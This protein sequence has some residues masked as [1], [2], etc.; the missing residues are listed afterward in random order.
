MYR[1]K[2]FPTG[3]HND[4]RFIHLGMSD[5]EFTGRV[6]ER[7]TAHLAGLP[8][9][10]EEVIAIHHHPPVRELFYP[11]ALTTVDQRVWLAYSGNRRMQDAVLSD[12]RIITVFCG[13]THAALEATVAGRRCINVGGDYD[14][15]RLVLLDTDSG[16]LKA[17]EFGR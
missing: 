5:E 10:V 1:R 4:G 11:I 13:H 6:V 12:E 9:E 2:L 14:F 8:A 3:R 17:W 15:K 7:F 16:E